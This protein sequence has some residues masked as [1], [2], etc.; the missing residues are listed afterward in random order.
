MS[1]AGRRHCDRC[2]YEDG[3]VGK[4]FVK[5]QEQPSKEK[6][7]SSG[8]GERMTGLFKK[9][10]SSWFGSCEDEEHAPRL[11]DTIAGS[12]NITQDRITRSR[13]AGDPPDIVVSPD[14][15]ALGLLGFYRAREAIDIGRICVH[16][17]HAVFANVL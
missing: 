9:Y 8:V 6:E 16:E 2:E 13:L 5:A 17:K 1:R 7:A 14:L 12:I 3:I 11:L 4:H 10:T 15:S